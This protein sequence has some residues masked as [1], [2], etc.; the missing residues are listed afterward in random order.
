MC[1]RRSGSPITALN[2][3]VGWERGRDSCIGLA[4]RQSTNVSRVPRLPTV[5][6]AVAGIRPKDLDQAWP[7]EVVQAWVKDLV[8]VRVLVGHALHNDLEVR[9]GLGLVLQHATQSA[10]RES[11]AGSMNEW[12]L[13]EE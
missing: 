12:C 9:A 11:W 13:Q 5:D 2:S 6:L 1:S 3:A 4:Q 7:R 10:M 8:K